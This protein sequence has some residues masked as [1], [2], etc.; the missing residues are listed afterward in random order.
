MIKKYE[1]KYEEIPSYFYPHEIVKELNKYGS[2]GWDVV[3]FEYCNDKSSP[4]LVFLK[5]EMV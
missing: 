5:R 4:H 2:E 3:H 1:Y